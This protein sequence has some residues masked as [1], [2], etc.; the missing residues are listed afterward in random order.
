MPLHL[1][2]RCSV[3]VRVKKDPKLKKRLWECR[4]LNKHN[5]NAEPMTD[6]ANDYGFTW[7]MVENHLSKHQYVNP[8]Q[9]TDKELTRIA[10]RAEQVAVIQ[11]KKDIVEVENVWDEVITKAREGIQ[12]GSIKLTAN[13]LLKAAKDKTDYNLK[14]T[15]QKLQMMEMIAHFAS[16]EYIGSTAYDDQRYL[17]GQTTTNND[18]AEISTGGA[19]QGA[20]GSSLIYN[21]DAGD[22]ATSRPSEVFEGDDF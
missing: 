20:F 2:D 9:M 15:G 3:C 10:R 14:K 8:E 18:P 5:K 19:L 7:R 12:D 16:G 13:H 11:E 4:K 21:R 17:E 1:T 22:A 6:I